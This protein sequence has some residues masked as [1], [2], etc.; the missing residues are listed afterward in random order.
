MVHMKCNRSKAVNDEEPIEHFV[1]ETL[2][3]G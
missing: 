3:C 2:I 1:T